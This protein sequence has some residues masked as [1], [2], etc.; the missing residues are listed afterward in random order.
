MARGYLLEYETFHPHPTYLD[1]ALYYLSK[2]DIT[3]QDYLFNAKVNYY[4]LKNDFNSIKEI[5]G[6]KGIQLV[7][8]SLLTEIEY[9]NYDAW[10][11]YRIGQAYENAGNLLMAGYFYEKAV[12]LA[13]YILNFQNKYGAFLVKSGKM[14]KAKDVFNFIINE[15]PR[16][17]SAYVNL[18]YSNMKTGNP[19]KAKI[20]YQK[21]LSLDP[22]HI[23]ALT[24]LAGL[25]FA[26]GNINDGNALIERVLKLDPD[27]K[28]VLAMKNKL[29][30][31]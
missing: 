26:E 20:N 23:Q 8:D 21:A 11:S 3:N 5:V 29:E 14:A 16:Y 28:Q 10:T 1:S 18:G 27:N 12:S 4:F 9:S 24:N 17:T 31:K 22:D 30:Q 7:L 15:D 2:E 6:S 13:K 19:E 25:N